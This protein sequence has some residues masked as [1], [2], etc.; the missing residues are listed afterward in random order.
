MYNHLTPALRR[1]AALTALCFSWSFVFATVAQAATCKSSQASGHRRLLSDTEMARIIGSSLATG[2]GGDGGGDTGTGGG[3]T[4]S[5]GTFTNPGAAPGPAYPWVGSV[6]GVKT[7]TGN[8]MTTLPIVS[9]RQRGGLP[10]EFTLTHNS[11]SS[12]N[13]ELGP[14]WRH[15]YDSSILVDG[16][17]N[18]TV[19]WGDGR[20][21][22]FMR[23]MDGSFLS[24]SGIHDV[25][26]K[27]SRPTGPFGGSYYLTT[28]EQ[29]V[30]AFSA[31]NSTPT[32]P[33]VRI[34]DEN[35]NVINFGYISGTN[36]VQTITDAT[37]RQITLG[38]SGSRLISVTDSKGRQ[39]TMN[40]TS[41]GDLWYVTEPAVPFAYSYRAFAYNAAHDITQ[42]QDRNNNQAYL[43]YN[44]DNT[45]AWERDSLGNQTNFSYGA[46]TTTITD[47]NGH[48]TVHTYN[49]SGQ[50]AS[51]TD[52]LGYAELYSYD[53]A[54]NVIQ[55]QDRRGFAWN[56]T[57]DSM[58]NVLTA[59]DPYGNTTTIAYNS[60]N[61]QLTIRLPLGR[62]VAI[63]YDSSDNPTQTLEKDANGNPD[64]ATS[65]AYGSGYGLL[66]SK[67]DAYNRTTL[68]GYDGNGY[69]NTMTTPLGRK[70][71]WTHDVLG[72]QTSRTDALNR[73]ATYTPDAWE[74]R[75][76]T[77]YPNGSAHTFTHDPNGNLTAFTDGIGTTTRAYDADNR[78][79]NEYQNG[80]RVVSHSYDAAG[81][82]G[83]L[84]TTTDFLGNVHSFVYTA[85]NQIQSASAAGQT[86]SYAYNPDGQVSQTLRPDGVRTDSY[87][88][89]NGWHSSEYNVVNATGAVLSAYDYV[90]NADGQITYA[91]E[92]TSTNPATNTATV[93]NYGY[94][95]LGHL[96][97]EVR[98]GAAPENLHYVYDAVGN[99]VSQSGSDLNGALSYDADD[100]LTSFTYS[101]T[102]YASATFGYDADGQ[103]TSEVTG[104]SPGFGGYA[105]Q[106]GYDYEGNLTGIAGAGQ[107]AVSFEY[108]GLDR[109]LGW[110]S[111]G[112][113]LDYQLDGNAPLTETNQTSARMNLY[114]NG[115][116]STGGETLLYDGLGAVR[117]TTGNG[118]PSVQWSGSYQGYGAL[119]SVSGSTGSHYFWGAASGYRSDG[120]GPTYAAAL[121]KVGARYYDPE[122]GCFLTRD[123]VLSEKPYA[124]CDSDPINCTDPTGHE[125]YKA[126]VTSQ[127][128]SHDG[129]AAALSAV[130]DGG[131]LE[132]FFDKPAPSAVVDSA[133]GKALQNAG[134]TEYAVGAAE[135][136]FGEGLL[137]LAAV[138]EI[139]TAG[140][141]SEFAGPIALTGLGAIADGAS[142]EG[143]GLLM[144]GIGGKI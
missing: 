49:N 58:G 122:F 139:A 83:L 105:T 140:L 33:L 143:L 136:K 13:G 16:S 92:G 110:Q 46:T 69:L 107:S 31:I 28:R 87:Y 8:K 94:D 2:G 35:S 117:Q 66:T 56:N 27:S 109:Q 102:S 21:C 113:R 59:A 132:V 131:S 24:P 36:L 32:F 67:S 26:T 104:L 101:G 1:L 84:S 77:A 41:V 93:T 120:F 44:A 128:A 30:C 79:L 9:W 25:L 116:V 112:A 106:Y 12:R 37:G 60:H 57:Y 103:R 73:T 20:V 89:D 23:N 135:M 38:Y 43:G 86:V 124:Y 133:F 91:Q 18:A 121:Q 45:L 71:Q 50:I 99:R 119:S 127:S 72:F 126:P 88:I 115:L 123:T 85:R 10:V 6:D 138:I 82:G 144:Q 62:S 111:G 5:G 52:A 81:Q 141:G 11:L 47:P 114:G 68:Y 65:Y 130:A 96:S 134:A 63:T 74:R 75:V 15:S 78:L 61:K 118:S 19:Y 129:I 90:F 42:T 53:G 4:G 39:W 76:S 7:Y 34:Y 17:G 54:N 98:T 70:T 29:I 64:T 55:K 125:A 3:G 22:T 80:V 51:I 97:S 95:P 108:D 100:E 142:K 137:V 14:K 48:T 40:Y